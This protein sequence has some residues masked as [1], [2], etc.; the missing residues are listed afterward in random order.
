MK[1][2][3]ANGFRPTEG[4]AAATLAK[5]TRGPR[6]IFHSHPG[7]RSVSSA[8]RSVMRGGMVAPLRTSRSRCPRTGTSRVT[9]RTR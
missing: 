6:A 8:L 2:E 9:T 5:V 1:G 7:R 4:S 3:S